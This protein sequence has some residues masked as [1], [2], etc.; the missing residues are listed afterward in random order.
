MSYAVAG[1]DVV[2]STSIEAVG[3]GGYIMASFECPV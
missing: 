1:R 3:L 2:M